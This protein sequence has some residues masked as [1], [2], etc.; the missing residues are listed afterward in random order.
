MEDNRYPFLAEVMELMLDAVCVV[1]REG[2]FVFVNAAFERLF[3]YA[4]AEVIGKPMLAMVFPDDRENTLK[5]VDAIIAGEMRPIFE[6]RWMHKSGRLVHVMWSARWSEK[7]QVRIAVARDISEKK[8]MEAQLEHMARHDPLTG[9][10]NRALLQDRLHMAFAQARR[11]WTQLGLLFI[12]LDEFKQVND[13]HGHLIGDRLLQA[14]ADRL[15]SCLR[16]VDTAA[17]IG[18]DEFVVLINNIN[19]AEDAVRI[20]EKIRVCIAQPYPLDELAIGISSSIGVAR[21]PEHGADYQ[22][23]LKGA[24]SAMYRAKTSGGDRAVLL[25]IFE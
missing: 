22:Q 17:R 8:R 16:E 24:D 13:S 5:T 25:E 2:H 18:G 3:G 23:L 9:L 21:Y 20:A 15:R 12:D 7:H 4:P 11:E 19:S 10:P 6:N 14:V 1:D